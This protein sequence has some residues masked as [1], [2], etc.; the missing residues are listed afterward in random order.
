MRTAFGIAVGTISILGIYLWVWKIKQ[1][2]EKVIEEKA[3]KLIEDQLADKIGVKYE[4]IK[5]Y[6][7]EIERAQ[8]LKQKR[9][10]VVNKDTGKKLSIEK[11]IEN[12][13]FSNKPI[14]KKWSEFEKGIDTNNFDLLL[15][16]NLDT[17]LSEEDI[18]SAVKKYN[19]SLKFVYFTSEDMSAENYQLLRSVVRFVKEEGY[20]GDAITNALKS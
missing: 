7:Q 1:T 2:A 17:E 4:L 6:F 13:G 16:D 14:F 11:I 8:E 15:F 10:L 18:K 3:D 20:L 19:E 9:I 12:A 5:S